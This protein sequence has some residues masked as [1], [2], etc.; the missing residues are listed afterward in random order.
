MGFGLS[1]RLAIGSCAAACVWLAAGCA[2]TRPS[3]EL[4]RGDGTPYPGHADALAEAVDACRGVR[5]MEFLLA[6][7]GSRGETSLR[8]RVRGAVARPGSLRL[9]GLAPFGSP[10]FVLVAA[11]EAATLLLPRARQ[12]VRDAHPREMLFAL[13]GLPLAPDDLR[14]VLTGCVV[15][16]PRSTAARAYGND[17]IAVDLAGGATA[18]LRPVDGGLT[19]VAG[20]RGPLTVAYEAHV[21]GLPRRVRVLVEGAGASA[22][23]ELT[24]ELSQVSVNTT[25]HPEVFALTVG[26]DFQTVALEELTGG[27]PLREPAGP[28]DPARSTP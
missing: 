11:P 20:A 26:E 17:W 25:L 18:Y 3:I 16:E 6:L 5:T 19:V 15:P 4:P 7:R 13:A 24:A 28:P 14:A 23:A 22:S 1:R 9:E 12:V 21:R 8:G 2:A 10:R 27:T